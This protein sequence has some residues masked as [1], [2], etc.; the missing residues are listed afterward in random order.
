MTP[1]YIV[2]KEAICIEPKER[3]FPIPKGVPMRYQNNRGHLRIRN[4]ERMRS[5]LED[6]PYMYRDRAKRPVEEVGM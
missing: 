6:K 5:Y 2:E 3:P 1:H 4:M